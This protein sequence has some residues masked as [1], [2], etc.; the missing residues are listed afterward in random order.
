[1]VVCRIRLLNKEFEMCR[2]KYMVRRTQFWKITGVMYVSAAR[3][4]HEVTG[5]LGGTAQELQGARRLR[6]T[7]PWTQNGVREILRRSDVILRRS[8]G[9]TASHA[10]PT[11]CR[12]SVACTMTCGRCANRWTRP[13]SWRSEGRFGSVAKATVRRGPRG[14]VEARKLCS[15][16]ISAMM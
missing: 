4:C 9:S 12:A 16:Y 11:R 2:V 7:G 5:A 8:V 1:M 15:V 14:V 3:C 13:C 6:G 10:M